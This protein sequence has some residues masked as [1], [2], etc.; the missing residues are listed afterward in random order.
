[1]VCVQQVHA[2]VLGFASLLVQIRAAFH[3][4]AVQRV[5]ERVWLLPPVR[6]L[7]LEVGGKF[8]LVALE[9]LGLLLELWV[10]VDRSYDLLE[11]QVVARGVRRAAAFVLL[12]LLLYVL[13]DPLQFVVGVVQLGVGE[14]VSP[15]VHVRRQ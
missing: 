6:D 5:E 12:V 3:E 13:T 7:D 14:V 15:V 11:V 8:L 9:L 1:M 4:F 2:V 10:G